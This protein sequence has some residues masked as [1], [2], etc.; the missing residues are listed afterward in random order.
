HNTHPH[1]TPTVVTAPSRMHSAARV[2]RRRQRQARG[3]GRGGV[4]GGG[5]GAMAHAVYPNRPVGTFA[6]QA[7][8]SSSQSLLHELWTSR[9]ELGGMPTRYSARACGRVLGV[10]LG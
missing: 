4:G 9:F 3:V 5:G 8:C 7:A 2:S 10:G 6:L 1:A